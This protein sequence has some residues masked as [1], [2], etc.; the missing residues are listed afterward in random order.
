MIGSY[1]IIVYYFWKHSAKKS[2]IRRGA[3]AS[4]QSDFP[5]RETV[6][7]PGCSQPHTTF[8]SRGGCCSQPSCK[9]NACECGG[10]NRAIPTAENKE[11]VSCG[12]SVVN[13]E[14]S[15]MS[16]KLEQPSSHYKTTACNFRLQCK[17]MKEQPNPKE[18]LD[19]DHHHDR[20]V[21]IRD[22]MS[23]QRNIQAQRQVTLMGKFLGNFEYFVKVRCNI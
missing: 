1:A 4:E 14:G 21:A 6:S 17:E 8:N 20:N 2:K 3:P 13:M 10:D 5:Q 16:M 18:Q 15:S 22:G 11:S 7:S 9:C 19:S 12:I 23:K